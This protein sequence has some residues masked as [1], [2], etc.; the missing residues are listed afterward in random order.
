[1][2]KVELEKKLKEI[3]GKFDSL[4]QSRLELDQQI[5]NIEDEKLRLQG[6]WRVFNN[7]LEKEKEKIKEAEPAKKIPKKKAN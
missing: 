7:M 1:M 6:E 3:E 5:R 4:H 2:S